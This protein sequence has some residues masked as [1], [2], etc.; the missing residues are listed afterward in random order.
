MEH[1]AQ[2]EQQIA[3]WITMHLTI[4]ILIGVGLV[5]TVVSR[6]VQLRLFP[7][8]VRTVLG[9][10]KGADGGISSFQ[11]ATPPPRPW[12]TRPT[13]STQMLGVNTQIMEPTRAMMPPAMMGRR[14][15]IWSEIAPPRTWPVA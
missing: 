6:G 14:R 15:P 7:E 9:S 10:R 1:I 5:L 13:R 11:E 3:D 12:K 4:F 2:I 8:M